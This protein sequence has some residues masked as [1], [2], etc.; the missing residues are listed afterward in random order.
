MLPTVTMQ[1]SRRTFVG[2]VKAGLIA[3]AL[4]LAWS[5]HAAAQTPATAEPG[6]QMQARA[7][8]VAMEKMLEAA[9]QLGAQRVRAQ[10]QAALPYAPDMLVISGMARARG[11]WL[12]GYG[13]FFDVDVPAMRKSLIWTVQMLEQNDRGLG[14][15]LATLKRIAAT[16]DNPAARRELQQTLQRIETQVSPPRTSA[17]PAGSTV[18][19]MSEPGAGRVPAVSPDNAQRAAILED[20]GAVYT[21]EVKDALVDIMV[22]YGGALPV[23]PNEWLTVAARDQGLSRLQ[24]GD[25]YESSTIVVRIKGADLTAFRAGQI[26]REQTRGRVELREY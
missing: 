26:D 7:K 25:P 18:A 5:G 22:D 4:A 16:V 2:G 9:V 10:V 20:P 12:E 15:E 23:A 6:A 8:L 1:M 13:V 11:F 19:A 14:S 21:T 3:G 17:P 24:P